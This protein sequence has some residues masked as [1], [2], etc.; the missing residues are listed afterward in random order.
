MSSRVEPIDGERWCFTVRSSEPR[1][2]PYRVDLEFYG[3]NGSCNCADFRT[4][5]E[6]DL[7]RGAA[8]GFSR[9]KHI[10]LARA[11]VLNTLRFVRGDLTELTSSFSNR[12]LPGADLSAFSVSPNVTFS[13]QFTLAGPRLS[14]QGCLPSNTNCE[15]GFN[16]GD[17]YPVQFVITREASS[18]VPEPSA[19]G[20]SALARVMLW[21]AKR[22]RPTAALSA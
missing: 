7:A 10:R 8:T 5:H 12:L 11:L 22:R 2:A 6:P 18:T 17:Q 16:D 1:H 19:L 15:E 4:R 3:G 13:L 21:R 14:W 20:L 9:C